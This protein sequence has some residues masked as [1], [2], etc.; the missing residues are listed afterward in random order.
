MTII[1]RILA[2]GLFVLS[3]SGCAEEVSRNSR[4]LAIGDSMLAWH[5]GSGNAITEVAER[6]IGEEIVDRSVVGARFLYGLPI[7][8][9]MGLNISKQYVLGSWDW[10]VINGGGNDLWFGCGCLDC[11]GTIDRMISRDGR[12]GKIPR[13]ISEA[14][15]TG[16]RVIF[17]GYLHSPGAFSIIDHCKT[18][19]IDFESRISALADRMDGFFYLKASDIVPKGDLSYHS[20]D[21]IHPSKKGSHEVGIRVAEIILRGQR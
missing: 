21:R 20:A 10:V 3:L 7:T 13:L 12:S 8:G 2:G 18:E 19:D 16:A 9:A 1:L 14:R 6:E 15:S 11:D 17:V 4:I 5:K